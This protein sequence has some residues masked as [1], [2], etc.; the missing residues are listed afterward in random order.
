MY[1]PKKIQIRINKKDIQRAEDLKI[2][3]SK[4]KRIY[5]KYEREE[6]LAKKIDKICLLDRATLIWEIKEIDYW[7]QKERFVDLSYKER[8]Y[9]MTRI[10]GKQYLKNI[11]FSKDIYCSNWLYAN[12]KKFEKGFFEFLRVS[13]EPKETKYMEKGADFYDI[14]KLLKGFEECTKLSK[15]GE[16]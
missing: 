15:V 6:K 13:Y 8:Q 7:E 10:F 11:S 1:K 3:F 14:E 2:Q 5:L 9:A 4:S 16:S 12:K